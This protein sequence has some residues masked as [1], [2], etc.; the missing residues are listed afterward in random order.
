MDEEQWSSIAGEF[1]PPEAPSGESAEDN[2]RQY[3]AEIGRS[4]LLTAEGEAE[5]GRAIE[6]GREAIG[7]LSNANARDRAALERAV[8]RARE[9]RR[10]LMESNLRLVVS[11]A[12][13]YRGYGLSLEDLIQEGNIG[14]MR[15]VEKF[16]Y[17]LGFRFSTYATH[18]IRQAVG[19]AIAQ[20]AGAIRVPTYVHETRNKLGAALTKLRLELSREPSADELAREVGLTT[21]QIAYITAPLPRVTSLD[22]PVVGETDAPLGAVIEDREAVDPGDIAIR[23]ALQAELSD[24][25]AGLQESERRVLQLRFGLLD[26][27]ARTLRDIAGELGLTAERIRQIEAGALRRLRESIQGRRLKVYWE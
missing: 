19:R 12:K 24:A 26:G 5:L 11:I 7:R 17:R 20:K 4:P 21:A 9:A 18:W 3:L 27:Y 10:Q 23:N 22:A 25:L 14:L 16:D 2:L 6:A 1:A 13:R 8:E 15:A